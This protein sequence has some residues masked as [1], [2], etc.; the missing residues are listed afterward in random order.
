MPRK[1]GFQEKRK[2]NAEKTERNQKRNMMSYSSK[3]RE[4]K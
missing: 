2:G 1:G 3:F 4:I